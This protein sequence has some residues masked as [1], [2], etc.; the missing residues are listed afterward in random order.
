MSLQQSNDINQQQKPVSSRVG[1]GHGEA[2]FDPPGSMSRGSSSGVTGTK[3]DGLVN[4]FQQNSAFLPVSQNEYGG[5]GE[6]GAWSNGYYPDDSAGHVQQQHQHQPM[7]GQQHYWPPQTPVG[8]YLGH[9]EQA[10]PGRTVQTGQPGFNMGPNQQQ[11]GQQYGQYSHYEGGQ[12]QQV[13]YEQQGVEQGEQPWP[14][15]DEQYPEQGYVHQLNH[16]HDTCT[17]GSGGDYEQQ[18]SGEGSEGGQ[19]IPNEWTH[20]DQGG[21]GYFDQQQS[22]L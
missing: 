20:G 6:D 11:L 22:D 9:Y 1:D 3:E 17:T 5:Y 8:Q 13:T 16:A 4:H 7:E 18:A 21:Y 2:T 15:F 14:Q 10:A 12:P 19:G